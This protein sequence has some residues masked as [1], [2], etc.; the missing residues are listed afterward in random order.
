MELWMIYK[1][2]LIKI[3]KRKN[4]LILV[5][6]AI[7]AFIMA[8]GISTGG[9]TMTGD[10]TSNNG[11]FACLEFIG[12]LWMFFS[13]LG[14]WGILLILVAAFQFSGEIASGQIK[15]TLL[16]I[17]KRGR[18]IFGKFLALMTVVAGAFAL[19]T[20]SALGSYYLFIANSSLGNGNFA[21]ATV[22]VSGLAASVGFIYLHLALF[23]ALTFLA[24]LYMSPFI[25]FITALIG[26]FAVNYLINSNAFTFVKY[27]ALSVSNNLIAG[28]A[29]YLLPALLSSFLIIGCLLAISS[30]LFKRVDIK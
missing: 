10:A 21:S 29:E 11:T 7:L 5:I 26:L 27:S 28:D 9:L 19:F 8:F 22:T 6:P 30:L 13:G 24:G 20:L 17:G 25:A 2:E 15:M 3:M 1:M 14:I 23:M 16:R 4:S 18:V 12:T